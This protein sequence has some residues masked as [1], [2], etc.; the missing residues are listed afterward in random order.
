[1]SRN[2]K[3]EPGLQQPGQNVD[4]APVERL[5]VGLYAENRMK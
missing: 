2:S 4:P 3:R 1:M 5:A